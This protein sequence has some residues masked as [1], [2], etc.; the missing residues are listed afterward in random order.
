MTRLIEVKHVGPRKHVQKLLEELIDRVED[1]LQGV[2]R[3]ATSMHVVFEENTAHKLYRIS[4][5]CHVPGHLVAAR[6][7]GHKPGLI[8]RDAFAELE[9]QLEKQLAVMRHEPERRQIRR[10]R[11][12]AL[13]DRR[14][15]SEE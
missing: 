5:T 14:V 13:S 10:D 6:E 4:L 1:K 3:D 8:I 9:R 11:R 12:R 2:P 15:S 7:E